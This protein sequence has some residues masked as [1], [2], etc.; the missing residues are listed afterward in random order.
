MQSTAYHLTLACSDIQRSKLFYNALF[1]KL[2]WELVDQGEEWA[3][4]SDGSF[5][6]WIVPAE[7]VLTGKHQFKSVGYH[8]F[9]FRVSS[10]TVV[11][12]VYQW[13]ISQDFPIVDAPA[14]YPEYQ[15]DYFAVFFLDPDGMKLEVVCVTD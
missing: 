6:L 8:H 1:E 11:E 4:Y 13:C 9:A 7:T 2:D 12:S 14:L 5:T 3:G 10:K 15:A